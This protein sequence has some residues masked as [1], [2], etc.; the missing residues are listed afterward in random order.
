M[1]KPRW[2]R[3]ADNALV[4]GSLAGLPVSSPWDR[5]FS[6]YLIFSA[7][8]RPIWHWENWKPAMQILQPLIDSCHE[9]AVIESQQ[10]RKGNSRWIRS[11]PKAWSEK[12]NRYW[13]HG[14]K[15]AEPQLDDR[16]FHSMQIWSPSG[17]ICDRG[18]LSPDFFVDVTNLNWLAEE[19]R[20][21]PFDTLVLIALSKRSGKSA[22]ERQETVVGKLANLLSAKLTVHATRPWCFRSHLG[23]GYER[24]LNYP[25]GLLRPFPTPFDDRPID[26]TLLIDEWNDVRRE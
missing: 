17:A 10:S 8:S 26:K 2:W 22:L 4:Y 14:S 16:Q 23:A 18:D 3:L 5:Q 20:G 12:A 19:P 1:P 6:V 15:D 7:S 21:L 11:T 24:C 25:K 13:T 9:P